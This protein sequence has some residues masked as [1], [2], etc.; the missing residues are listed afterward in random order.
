MERKVGRRKK[1]MDRR[2]EGGMEEI[3][4]RGGKGKI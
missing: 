1:K 2:K 4:E 3:N